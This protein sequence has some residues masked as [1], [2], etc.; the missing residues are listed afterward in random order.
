MST[1]TSSPTAAADR[2]NSPVSFPDRESRNDGMHGLLEDWAE[3]LTTLTDEAQASQA[4]QEWLD[5]HSRFTDYS[6]RNTLL[7]HAQCPDATKVA[8][9]WTWQHDFDRHV[10]QG[11]DAIWIWAPI[12]TEECPKC[13]NSDSYHDRDNLDCTYNDD[14]DP[15]SWDR[16]VV[17]FKPLACSTSPK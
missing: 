8:G 5:V 11:E 13:G 14:N 10:K 17:D 12:I 7:I 1:D 15:D 4:F 6:Y 3:D 2:P 9:Y 16:G